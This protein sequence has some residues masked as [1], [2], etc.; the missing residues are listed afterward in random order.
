MTNNTKRKNKVQFE[1][2]Q[3]INR[4]KG[5]VISTFKQGKQ[6]KE[7]ITQIFLG[8]DEHSGGYPYWTNYIE[9]AKTFYDKEKAL[10]NMNYALSHTSLDIIPNSVTIYIKEVSYTKED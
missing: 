4:D 8:I 7:K 5:Y 10:S 3:I 2:P 9:C 6:E 1:V